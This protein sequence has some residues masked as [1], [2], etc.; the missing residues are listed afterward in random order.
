M[1]KL[2]LYILLFISTEI[3]AIEKLPE[4]IVFN[5]QEYVL[6]L[7]NGDLITGKFVEEI[8]SAEYG[9]GVKFKT[10]FGIA[11]IYF[12]EIEEIRQSEKYNRHN[13]RHFIMPTA[14]PI[15]DDYFVGIVELAFL[16]G[17][18]G[19]TDYLSVTAGHSFVP[20]IGSDNQI[21][22]LNLKSTFL[23]KRFENDEGEYKGSLFLAGGANLSWINDANNLQ[24][25]FVNATFKG[26]TSKLT[27][28]LFY[29]YS[30]EDLYTFHFGQAGSFDATYNDGTFGIGL[31]VEDQFWNWRGV[32]IM[33][34]LW[35]S[36]FS[37]PSNTGVLLGFRLFNSKYSADVGLMFFTAPFAAPFVNFVFTPF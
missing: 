28:N 31:G 11:P 20:Y 9:K 27:A 2:L 19:I 29:K 24:H 25:Y 35:N 1:K 3:F 23:N 26:K 5:T 7:S 30:G 13:H 32:N 16:Y 6:R 34:E 36:D 33:L 37:R 8:E 22:V 14:E 4:N 12:F 21:S 10:N 15:G 18:F 17:G